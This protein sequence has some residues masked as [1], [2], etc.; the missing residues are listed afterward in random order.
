MP[1]LQQQPAST[2]H[3]SEEILVVQTANLFKN[4]APWHGIYNNYQTFLNIITDKKLFMPRAHAETNPNFKQ[5]IPYMIF[6]FDHKIFVMQRKSSAS[7]QRLASKFSIGIG[8][9]MRQEDMQTNDIIDWASR[10][11]DE[12]VHYSGQQSIKILGVLND[13]SNAVSKVHLGIIMLINA[14]SDKIS[15]KDE[16]KSGILLT[17]DECIALKPQMESWSQICLDFLLQEK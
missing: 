12:E 7:E 8:G 6:M 10:E 14:N 1:K 13:D 15:I 2:P 3:F 17:I 16:H 9:H 11:F 4:I 5:I